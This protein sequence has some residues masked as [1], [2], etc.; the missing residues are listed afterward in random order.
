MPLDPR[1][2]KLPS[3]AKSEL[4]GLR[5][6]LS[7]ARTELAVLSGAMPDATVFTQQLPSMRKI[8]I[9]NRSTHIRFIHGP[10]EE[11]WIECSI[12]D[13]NELEI[14][15]NWRMRVTMNSSNTFTVK[16]ERPH[17]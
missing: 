14:H 8:P 1:E 7:E 5:D 16:S 12:T 10:H 9:G 6:E 4:R 13:S 15:G 2:E 17:G 3:W 11:E